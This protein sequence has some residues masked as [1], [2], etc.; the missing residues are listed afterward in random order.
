MEKFLQREIHTVAYPVF[1][2][3]FINLREGCKRVI[4]YDISIITF[5]HM[6]C[7]KYCLEHLHTMIRAKLRL[8]GRFLLEMKQLYSCI[9]MH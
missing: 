1:R 8:V 9:Y 2:N 6:L 7:E 4:Q 5:D 3:I